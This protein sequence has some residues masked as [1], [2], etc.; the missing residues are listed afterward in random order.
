[1]A[2]LE[3][4]YYEF[5]DVPPDAHDEPAWVK[6]ENKKPIEGLPQIYW[7][8]GE[9]WYEANTWALSRLA[10]NEL[11]AE[12]VKRNMKHIFRLAEFTEEVGI[13][14]RHFPTRIEDQV[15]RRF[16]KHL[17]AAVDSGELE[18]STASNCMSTSIQFYRF[19]AIHKLVGPEAP[20][21]ED[22][23][24]ILPLYDPSGFKRLMVRTTTNLSIPNRKRAGC[25]LEDGLL[26]LSREHM[27]ELL[28][29][30]ALRESVE[31]SLMLSIGFFTGA[32]LGSIVTLSVS[33]LQ[34]ARP[35]PR[36]PKVYLL[37]VG[38]GTDVSTKSSV[39]GD[40]MVPEALLTDLRLY[41]TS[42]KRLLREVKA[43]PDQKDVLFLTRGGRPYTV[44]TVDK[45]VEEMRTHTVARGMHFM[46]RFRF[47][48]SRA[49]FG[50]W[51]ME[52]ALECGATP[53]AA[54]GFVRDAMLHKDERATWTYIKFRDNVRAKQEAANEFSKAFASLKTVNWKE[55]NE[56]AAA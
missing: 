1:M 29:H 38:P 5:F 33:G 15:L 39:S 7:A 52:M 22:R 48:Q 47:H 53:A 54:I 56:R 37:P 8:N 34:T 10:S 35:D 27:I 26:P 43:P 51:M 16:R 36:I 19:A 49:T 23:K 17:V 4:I 12:T 6:L 28:A 32:R 42:T 40:L 14:W 50:T 3:Y 30:A 11:D 13:D 25:T 9:G 41:A 2:R 44:G 46:K 21:W 31:L 18:S 55:L 45:L 20:M 24:V